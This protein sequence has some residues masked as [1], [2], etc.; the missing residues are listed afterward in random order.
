[1]QNKTIMCAG[2]LAL[3]T[4]AIHTFVGTPEIQ[5]PLLQ[6]GIDPN[7]ALL[8]YACWHLV[9]VTLALSGLILMWS[10]NNVQQARVVVLF[11]S[12]LWLAFGMVFIAT[13]MLFGT[14]S[15]LLVLP[16]WMLLIPVGLL[17]IIGAKTR[18]PTSER[19]AHT[20]AAP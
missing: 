6:S 14:W 20:R 16:Q 7:V 15:T 10:A 11:V 12:V 18:M 1:M 13:A 17:G 2:L 5:Q 19:F 4:A 9:T 8:L 3:F